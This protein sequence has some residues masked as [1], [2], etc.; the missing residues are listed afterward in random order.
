MKKYWVI[1]PVFLLFISL[2]SC[3]RPKNDYVEPDAINSIAD[4]MEKQAAQYEEPIPLPK[5]T[6]EDKNKL[7]NPEYKFQ[8]DVLV[9]KIVFNDP[10]LGT[11]GNSCNSCH[12]DG[13]NLKG[14]YAKYPYEADMVKLINECIKSRLKGQPIKEDSEE[15]AKLMTY[16]YS[17]N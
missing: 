3:D 1:L 6:Q 7:T 2:V 5:E 9:G 8:A 17:L 4:E 14:T 13:E 12:K 10:H 15:M 16:V 11:T